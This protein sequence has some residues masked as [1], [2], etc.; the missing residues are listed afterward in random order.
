MISKSK[1]VFVTALEVIKSTCKSLTCSTLLQITVKLSNFKLAFTK[2][3]K[4]TLFIRGFKR[5]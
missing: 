5:C 1:E 2:F 3:K 4:D